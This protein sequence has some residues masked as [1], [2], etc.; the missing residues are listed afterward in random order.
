MFTETVAWAEH[1]SSYLGSAYLWLGAQDDNVEGRWQHF[2]S[3]KTITYQGRWR[4]G[5]PNGGTVE[6]CLVM[7]YGP[8]V[9]GLWSD[10][11]CFDSYKKCMFCEF[12][13]YTTMFLK[14]PLVCKNSP[15]N[16]RY[17][18]RRSINNRPSF[19][20]YRHSDIFWNNETQAWTLASK[21]VGYN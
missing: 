19:T 11:A 10:F 20:G 3:N 17:I 15:F 4:G 21:R 18:L 7:M 14:G 8:G 1:C 9:N 16:S 13:N 5:G 12:K 2:E 6:N